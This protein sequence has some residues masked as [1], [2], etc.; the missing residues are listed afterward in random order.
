[1]TI[2]DQTKVGVPRGN[3]LVWNRMALLTHERD[4]PNSREP[5][6]AALVLRLQLL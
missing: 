1:M 2:D 4:V 3:R 6:E 5:H